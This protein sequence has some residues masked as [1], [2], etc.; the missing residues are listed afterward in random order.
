M[1]E[2]EVDGKNKEIYSEENQFHFSKSSERIFLVTT[3]HTHT[4]MA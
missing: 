4:H 3:T 2:R 1:S